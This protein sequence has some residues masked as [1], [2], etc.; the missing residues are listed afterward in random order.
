MM[1]MMGVFLAQDAELLQR[2]AATRQ[3]RELC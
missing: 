3:Y 2:S 1:I